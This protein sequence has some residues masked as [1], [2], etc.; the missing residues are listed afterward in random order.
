MN[1]DDVECGMDEKLS[2]G[3]E[4]S[5][6]EDA[7]SDDSVEEIYVEAAATI[8]AIAAA[9]INAKDDGHVCAAG[10]LCGMKAI[11][12]DGL[13]SCMNCGKLMHGASCEKLWAERGDTCKITVEHLTDLGKKKTTTVGALIYD[14]CMKY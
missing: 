4:C 6:D 13:H 7:S 3:D 1:F 9:T 14:F 2:S 8:N 5:S 10:E 12:L 11:P